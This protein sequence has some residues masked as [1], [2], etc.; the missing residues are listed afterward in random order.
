MLVRARC[1]CLLALGLLASCSGGDSQISEAVQAITV[2]SGFSD[3]V[4][5]TAINEPVALDFLPDKTLLVANR[6]GK[7]YVV[8]NKTSNPALA[9]AIDLTSKIC[10]NRERGLLGIAV[11]PEF[12]TTKKVYLYYTFKKNPSAACPT[13]DPN[14]ANVVNRVSRF[15]YNATSKTLQNEQVILDN[16]LSNNGWHNAGDLKFGPDGFLY[17]SVGDSGADLS[18]GA[19]GWGNSNARHKSILQ[20]KVLRVTKAGEPAPG[21]PW[22]SSSGSRRCAAPGQTPIYPADDSKPC[23]EAYAWGLRNPYRLAFKPATSTFFINDVGQNIPDDWEEI[24]TGQI[25]A[26]YGWNNN[27]GP[28]T[29]SGTTAPTHAYQTGMQVDGV[30]CRCITG[31][32]FVTNGSW[33]STYDNSYLFADYTCGAIFRIKQSNGS[34]VRTTFAKGLGSS[35]LVHLGFGPNPDGGLSLFY[36]S[37]NGNKVGRIDGPSAN[38]APVAQVVATPTYG[39]LP[40]TVSIDGSGSHDPHTGDT[41]TSYAWSFGD[42]TATQTTTAPTVSHTYT[43]SGAVTATLTVQDSRTPPKTDS[44]TVALYPGDLPPAVTIVQPADDAQFVVGAPVTLQASASDPD[45]GTLPAS[46]LTWDVKKVHDD[47]THPFATMTGNNVSV[48]PDGPEDLQAVGTSYFRIEVTAKDSRGQQ[49]TDQVE[50]FPHEVPITVQTVPAGLTLK[51]NGVDLATPSTFD[52]WQGWALPVGAPAQVSGG[53]SYVFDHWSDGGAASHTITVPAAPAT[54]TASFREAPPT[55]KINFQTATA[56]VPAG[57]LKDDGAAFGPRDGG[58]SYGWDQPNPLTR[59][60]DLHPDPR[61]DTTILMEKSGAQ[62]RW[63][64]ALP[65]GEYQVYLVAGDAQYYDG[66]YHITA[67]GQPFLDGTPTSANHFVEVTRNV[68]VTDGRLTL[69]NGAGSVLSRVCFVEITRVGDAPF[70]AD[71]NFQTATAAVP[72]GYLKDDGAAFGPRSGGLSYGW[73]TSNPLTRDRDVHPDQRYDTTILM[74]KQGTTYTWELAVP[75]GVYHVHLVAG[76]AQYY[77]GSYHITAEGQ[78]FLDGTP[79]STDHFVEV[80]GEVTVTD[81]RLTLANGPGSVYSRICFIEIDRI[82]AP[83]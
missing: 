44:A 81:G 31:G 67:E 63:E 39:G 45:D 58:L 60:R 36:L 21:N 32:T 7:V 6:P 11:D 10:S 34:W 72:A 47:H 25:G 50:I 12:A 55:T 66:S 80:T 29:A 65:S 70:A 82:G 8:E 73:N 51:V 43:A 27:Q 42:G 35:S 15:D 75:A 56:A 37:F 59:D 13:S 38:T 40:L 16:I 19:T 68:I 9:T 3:H 1:S 77:D 54:Y 23:R 24:E 71:I 74:E 14:G 78:P 48:V 41:I 53:T 64:L 57:Y 26:D 76:D 4:L 17:V 46:A 49:A 83:P 33:T 5:T 79:T 52:A 20:G 30:A 62:Y 69:A 18:S 2:P 61:Y 28:T 22:L